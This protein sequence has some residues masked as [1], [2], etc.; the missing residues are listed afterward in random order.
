MSG[1]CSR[2]ITT[3]SSLFPPVTGDSSPL[4]AHAPTRPSVAICDPKGQQSNVANPG[5]RSRRTCLFES[6]DSLG[7][8][9][10]TISLPR[11]TGPDVSGRSL[12]WMKH[13][14]PAVPA[15]KP[16]CSRERVDGVRP[17][18]VVQLRLLPTFLVLPSAC[19]SAPRRSSCSSRIRTTSP[20]SA[21]AEEAP[22]GCL[23]RDAVRWRSPC[24]SA[25]TCIRVV[26]VRVR[27]ARKYVWRLGHW[28][29][30]FSLSGSS[31]CSSLL[32]P[33]VLAR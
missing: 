24:R 10:V 1:A 22:C 29:E 3:M 12:L 25:S 8:N 11:R 13:L 32:L 4:N 5:N 14:A 30:T 19:T 15:V 16:L 17:R 7:G 26:D 6:A 27:R 31:R 23:P 20:S 28:L 9:G 18:G 21:S 2:D 33:E